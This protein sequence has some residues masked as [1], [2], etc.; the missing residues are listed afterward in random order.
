M[1]RRD[2]ILALLAVAAASGPL[3]LRARQS[4]RRPYRIA[5]V[6]DFSPLWADSIL[7]ILA[8][9]LRASGRIEGR[10]YVIYRS[11]VLYGPDTTL[12]LERALEAKP[13]LIIV[14][15][16]GSAIDAYKRTKTIPIVMWIS[17]FPVAGGV[18]ESLARPGRNV[19]GLT[20]YAGGAF[21]GKLLDLLHAAKPSIRRVGFFMSY[22]PPYHPRAE[23]DLII[24]GIKDAAGLLGLDLRVFEIARPEQADDALAGVVAQDLDALVLTSDASIWPRR[25]QIMEFAVARRLPTIIDAGWTG[26][27]PQ[28]LL[29][30][31]ARFDILMRQA[32]AYVERILWQGAKPGD[33][34]IQLP[35]RFKFTVNLKTAKAI[36]LT[37]P[38]ALLIRADEVVR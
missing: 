17:G 35:A 34:P 11:G 13:D 25:R 12:A 8:Q 28:P 7:K 32:A 27:E 22:V 20:I 37:I 26:V 10:D 18:A 4:V 31:G 2:S 24:Q 33:L 6:P 14:M 36:G 23:T 16:L 5:L 19:T 15:N 1:R 21:F 9:A 29:A 38:Q 30:Y 3:P